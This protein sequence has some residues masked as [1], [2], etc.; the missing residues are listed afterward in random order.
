MDLLDHLALVD[1]P[2]FVAATGDPIPPGTRCECG[3]TAYGPGGA[4][5]ATTSRLPDGRW[6]TTS[7][8][9]C[10]ALAWRDVYGRRTT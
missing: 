8:C 3:T 7:H 10:R 9:N 6:L 2:A 5:N 1:S 4:L